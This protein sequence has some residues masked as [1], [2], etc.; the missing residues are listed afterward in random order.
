MLGYMYIA[1]LLF[2]VANSP[3]QAMAASF[4]RLLDHTKWL[5]STGGSSW[6]KDLSLTTQKTGIYSPGEIWTR[7]SNKQAAETLALDRSATGCHECC[8]MTCFRVRLPQSV[9]QY[10]LHSP[11]VIP[12][13]I[14]F[15]C[16]VIFSKCFY[17]CIFLVV[18]FYL[19]VLPYVL[20]F[21]FFLHVRPWQHT[22]VSIHIFL[23]LKYLFFHAVFSVPL[24]CIPNVCGIF[25]FAFSK[26]QLKNE[27]PVTCPSQSCVHFERHVLL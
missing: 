10:L 7:S 3:T 26:S 21:I 11:Y 14:S 22:V 25:F 20:L 13:L 1:C 4:L 12:V 18:H 8:V 24:Y 19:R 6:R 15:K 27:I 2:P 16:V 9:S 5:L 23:Y 17:Y